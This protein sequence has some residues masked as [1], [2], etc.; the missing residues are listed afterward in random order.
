V[1]ID[2]RT[3]GP[4]EENCYLVTDEA[5]GRAALIDPGDE[6]D[7]L[8]DMIRASGATLDAVWLTHAH[9]DHIGAVAEVKR[10][11]DVPIYLHPLDLPYYAQLS[12]RAA[13]MYGIDFEQPEGPDH[14]LADGQE[15]SCGALRFTVMHVPGHA[16]G[17]V[18]FTGHGVSFGG[19]LLFAGSI[20]R[21]D[22]PLGS[23]AD[24]SASLARY[25]AS[26]PD[27]TVVHPG[28]GPATTIGREKRT[29][30]FLVGAARLVRR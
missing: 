18:A 25:T 3:V 9:V 14:E 5:S 13:V 26:L 17:L 28:H 29:N 24:M 30:P 22:L 19:D 23:P 6:A 15:L 10:Q 11:F 8:L 2:H 4:F 27:E 7:R 20:G 21:T 12:A 1:R 16:P